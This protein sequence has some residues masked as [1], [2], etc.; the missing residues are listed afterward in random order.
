M[1]CSATWPGLTSACAGTAADVMLP[2]FRRRRLL[3]QHR[4]RCMPH[5]PLINLDMY[6]L[7]TIFD[8]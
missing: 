1:R 6:P 4:A 3:P 8:E 7:S 5:W 2:L